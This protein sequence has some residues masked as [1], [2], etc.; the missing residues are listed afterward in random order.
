MAW[1]G[2]KGEKREEKK[3][4][5]PN[6]K[7]K[8]EIIYNYKKLIPKEKEKML[9]TTKNLTPGTAHQEN[10]IGGPLQDHFICWADDISVVEPEPEPYHF[11]T[12]TIGTGTVILH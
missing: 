4:R 1:G 3:F 2:G 8:R 5:K 12:V 6:E 10:N 11:S 9:I 7:E